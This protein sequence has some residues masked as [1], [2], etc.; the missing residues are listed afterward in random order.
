M[1]SGEL[2]TDVGYATEIQQVWEHWYQC[3]LDELCRTVTQKK[4]SLEALRATPPGAKLA[5]HRLEYFCQ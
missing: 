4:A 1:V 2:Y 5:Y 3:G